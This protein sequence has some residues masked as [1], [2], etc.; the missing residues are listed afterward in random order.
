LA[1]TALAPER[2]ARADLFRFVAAC[3]YEPD[4]AF[5]EEGLF[6]SLAASAQRVDP[7]LAKHARG[8]GQ[9]FAAENL[10]ALRIDYT[11]LFLGPS[12]VYTRPYASEWAD[13]DAADPSPAYA[14]AGLEIDEGFHER[15]DHVAVELE[16]LYRLI[17]QDAPAD[18][19]KRFLAG[20]LGRWVRPFT[21]AV[22]TG[23]ESA[24]YRELA[25]L[26]ERVV[27]MESTTFGSE[28]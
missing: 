23:A 1:S 19:R 15:P 5:A 3:Y 11:R 18:L 9:A 13:G 27:A 16:F 2:L 28:V 25:E 22:R 7:E 14:E 20:H 6:D 17:H 26:T 4:P 8:L 10:D 24:F 21:E 12:E